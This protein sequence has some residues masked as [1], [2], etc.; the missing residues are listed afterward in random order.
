M[1]IE[2][3]IQHYQRLKEEVEK[4]ITSS[5]THL[6]LVS[7]LRIIGSHATNI[8]KTHLPKLKEDLATSNG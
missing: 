5:R 4:S 3:E 7:A 2:L 6:E 1:A 8:V